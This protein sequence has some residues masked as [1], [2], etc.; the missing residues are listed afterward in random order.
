MSI[1]SFNEESYYVDHAVKGADYV[2]GYNADGVLV[3][4]IEGVKDFSCVT[5]DGSYMPAESCVSEACNEVRH[6]NG[7]LVRR[8]GGAVNVSKVRYAVVGVDWETEGNY[9]Y[10]DITVEGILETD[11]PFV[12]VKTGDDNDANSE[13]QAAM[14]KVFRISTHQNRIRLWVKLKPSIAF[15]IQIKVVR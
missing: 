4:S 8:D 12:G 11:T 1:L 13:Y 5:F 9:Y 6:I 7:V 15:P 2:H 10:Q 14:S 3:V